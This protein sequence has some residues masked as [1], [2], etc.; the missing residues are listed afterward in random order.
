MFV[1]PEP[2]SALGI[3]IVKVDPVGANCTS[4]NTLSKSDATYPVCAALKDPAFT[5]DTMSPGSRLCGAGVVIVT[6]LEAF[7]VV[8]LQPD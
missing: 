6:I 8:I 5:K 3:W 4:N 2:D 7:V 1:V